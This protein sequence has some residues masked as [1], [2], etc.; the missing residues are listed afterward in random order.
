VALWTVAGRRPTRRHEELTRSYSGRRREPGQASMRSR[1]FI[2]SAIVCS[3]ALSAAMPAVAP[4]S[5]LLSGYGGPGQGSQAIIGSSLV[6]GPPN[7]GGG[8]PTGGG[9]AGSG[10]SASAAQGNLA[11]GAGSPSRASVGSTAHRGRAELRRGRTRA[12]VDVLGASSSGSRAH[13][14]SARDAALRTA[15]E[16]SDTLGVSGMDLLYILVAL[17]ALLLTGVVTRRIARTSTPTRGA[18]S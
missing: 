17:C 4:A 11:T 7:G 14:A 8:P 5:S 10:E 9:S 6:N 12:G 18:G 2:T 3:A 1:R 15:G 16:G 13:P